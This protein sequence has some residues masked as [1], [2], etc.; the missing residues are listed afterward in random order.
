MWRVVLLAPPNQGE[1]GSRLDEGRSRV[2]PLPGPA[3]VD[4]GSESS[5]LVARLGPVPFECGVIAGSRSV[6]PILSFVIPG[7]DDGK[8]A[9]VHRQ[10]FHFLAHGWFARSD[11][12]DGFDGAR[13]GDG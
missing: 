13:R 9:I 7:T 10:V 3:L 2:A 11:A 4:L 8:V 12:V 6:N 1:R 5:A